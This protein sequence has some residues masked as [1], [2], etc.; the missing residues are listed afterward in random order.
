MNGR[1]ILVALLA[2]AS[3]TACAV[4]ASPPTAPD[5]TTSSAG[6]PAWGLPP[7]GDPGTPGGL[8]TAA[9]AAD[10]SPAGTPAGFPAAAPVAL[11][12][13]APITGLDLPRVPWEGGPAYWSRFPKANAAGWADPGFFPIALWYNGFTTDDEVAYDTARG[14]NTYIGMYDDADLARFDRMGVYWIG[15]RL[16]DTF[17][18]TARNWVGEFLDDEVDGRFETAEGMALL[19]SKAA[20]VS[21][22]RFAMANYTWLML[23]RDWNPGL[24]E[25]YVNGYTD[26]VSV[27][28]YYYT[29]SYCSDPGYEPTFLV[30]TIPQGQCRTSSS[31]GRTMDMLRMRD[32][33]D[34]KRQSVWNF[35]EIYSGAPSE[36]T[37]ITPAQI[38]GAVMNSLIHE[39]RGIVY[40]NQSLAGSC[41]AGSMVRKT[42]NEPGSCGTAQVE[43][44][45]QVNLQIKRLAP[46]LNTQSYAWTFGADL[47]TMLKVQDGTAYVFAMIDNSAGP[48]ARTF[49]LPPELVGRT[50]TVVDEGRTI[51]VDSEG[52]FTDT[53]AAEY[54]YHIYAIR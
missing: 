39:A 47:D 6:T 40:F 19:A 11:P 5:A 31:Y 35:V 33:A 46:V 10:A 44:A 43:G 34:G 22:G 26:A 25:Q 3:L 9:S 21:N 15:S 8:P 53:F 32:G 17:T 27:D 4:Q 48:G 42:Q 29:V 24:A 1:R 52:R 45:S 37:P 41:I 14:F 18:P 50:V 51:P 54:S 38:K 49:Q 30:A 36:S 28:Q 16:N 13:S 20:Q 23:Q 12:A 2:M 7:T